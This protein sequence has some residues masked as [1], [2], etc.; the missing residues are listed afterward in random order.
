MLR[1]AYRPIDSIPDNSTKIL[2]DILVRNSDQISRH[3]IR[4]AYSSERVNENTDEVDRCYFTNFTVDRKPNYRMFGD[5]SR[6]NSSL[7]IRRDFET[8]R[9]N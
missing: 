1:R 9:N 8:S 2:E 3:K 4:Q 5:I 7:E 6:A